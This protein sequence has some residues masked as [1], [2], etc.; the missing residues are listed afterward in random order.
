MGWG[1]K[2]IPVVI[3]WLLQLKFSND[4]VNLFHS[5][6]SFFDLCESYI[7]SSLATFY[8]GRGK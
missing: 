3:Y 6:A 7:K 2:T 5:I 8:N 1:D 4:L